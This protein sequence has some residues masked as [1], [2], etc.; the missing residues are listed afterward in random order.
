MLLDPN[1]TLFMP[2]HLF[3]QMFMSK[4]H[5]YA[6]VHTHTYLSIHWSLNNICKTR[7]LLDVKH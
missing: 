1:C 6:H 3:S 4:A 5:T 7:S 2:S